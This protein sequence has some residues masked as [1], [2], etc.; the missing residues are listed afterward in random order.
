MRT[1]N[2]V[3]APTLLLTLLAGCAALPEAPPPKRNVILFLG[4]GMG[5]STITAARI[6]A[7]QAQGGSGEE[8]SLSFERFPNVALIK[9]YNTDAQV[10][11]SAGTMSAIMT[12][13]KT[14][15]GVISVAPVVA[16][17]DCA[18]S[19]QNPMPTLLE[20]AEDAGYAT[21]VIS[22]ARITHA[23]PAATYSHVPNRNWESDAQLPE[24][25]VAEGCRDIARQLVEFD[26]GDGIDVILGGGRAMF[27]AS[28]EA[29]PE[30]PNATGIRRDG[31]DLAQTWQAGASGRAYVWNRAG[32]DALDPAT[33]GQVLGL[34][35]PSHM[36]YEADRARDP[37]G[38]PSL[39]EMTRFAIERLQRNGSGYFLMI[40]GGRIDH[41][42]HE[43]NAYRAL[44]DTGAMA[45]AVSVAESL[46]SADDTLIIVTAD[47]SH[48]LTIN[49]YPGR[50]NPIL[51]KVATEPG[52]YTLDAQ[53]H[54]YTTL[55][56]ANGPGY[57]AEIPDLTNVDTED[58]DYLQIATLPMA[59]ETH[60]GE[61]VAAFAS[62]RNADQVHGV[63]EQNRLFDAMYQTLFP[64]EAR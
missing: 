6:F 3:L 12:G 24:N 21:G 36:Q 40:E 8:F 54:P 56:Y 10:P 52:N 50:G 27:L 11:D 5:I 35:E 33:S 14:R 41:A 9:T 15:A 16:R 32:F 22:T 2:R 17:N 4:D 47:H 13:T 44:V 7:G 42:H 20:M 61:D 51:G 18:G 34:F 58:P 1:L 25:A 19:L 48:T 55:S 31:A 53:G 62:G 29:D 49:G 64:G 39:A 60:G 57:Q 45:D 28:T 26:H 38:E 23:T 63:M 30:Y 46:T 37:G 43:G 59:G